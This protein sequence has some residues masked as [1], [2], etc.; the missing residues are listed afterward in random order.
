[1]KWLM[2]NSATSLT[3]TL[4]NC[5]YGLIPA[6]FWDKEICC[7]MLHKIEGLCNKE[8]YP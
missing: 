1:M 5:N 4:C 7:L 6:E 8:V 2:H 3:T